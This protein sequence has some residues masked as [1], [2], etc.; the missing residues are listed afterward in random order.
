MA[1]PLVLVLISV[2][3]HGRGG[4]AAC[5]TTREEEEAEEGG[6][7]KAQGKQMVRADKRLQKDDSSIIIHDQSHIVIS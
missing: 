2:V 5:V 1:K 7:G 4:R 6:R 3:A